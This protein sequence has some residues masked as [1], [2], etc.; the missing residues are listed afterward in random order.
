[1]S[2]SDEL[3]IWQK[4]KLLD[5]L[6]EFVTPHK[7]QLFFDSIK[8]RTRHL[9]I[10]LEDIY[11][12]HNASA[13]LRTCDCFGIQ[14]VHI[15]ENRNKYE[16]NRDVALGSNKWLNLFKYNDKDHNTAEAINTLKKKGYR[17]VATTL[18]RKAVPL[19]E[20]SI[21]NKFVLLFGTELTG[22]SEEATE[23]ADE[24]CKIPMVGFTESLNISV[25]VAIMVHYLSEKIRVAEID[26]ELSETEKTDILLDWARRVVKKPDVLERN[27]I[28][29]HL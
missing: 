7:Q 3:N 24:F 13:V 8:Y 20:L 18:H 29:Q 25:T 14:D 1:M 23:L 11:Q 17:M 26:W 21:D 16:V 2:G 12:S 22:L 28:K 27:F 9:G 19:N 15:V 5:Y 10:M 4:K 6:L